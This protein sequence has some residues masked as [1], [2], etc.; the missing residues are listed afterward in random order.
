MKPAPLK[1]QDVSDVRSQVKWRPDSQLASRRYFVSTDTPVNS[2]NDKELSEN[3]Q[4]ILDESKSR[5]APQI[6]AQ[7]MKSF[8]T[9]P[10]LYSDHLVWEAPKS[11]FRFIKEFASNIRIKT[12]E[13]D[14][15][16]SVERRVPSTASAGRADARRV[17]QPRVHDSKR[18]Q[19][20]PSQRGHRKQ[21]SFCDPIRQGGGQR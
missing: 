9:E 10:L 13:C 14:A 8:T 21:S 4:R 16:S 15:R 19:A 2:M 5:K 11:K 7:K 18:A 1:R 20:P 12:R 17:L 6:S 3:Y